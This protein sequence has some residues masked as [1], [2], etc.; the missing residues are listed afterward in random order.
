[1]CWQLG[2]KRLF[3]FNNKDIPASRYGDLGAALSELRESWMKTL[4][5]C[6]VE[7]GGCPYSYDG[8]LI[9]GKER[10]CGQLLS[11]LLNLMKSF[12]ED[13]LIFEYKV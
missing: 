4:L 10:L 5:L 6:R 7:G 13:L 2:E 12:T 9:N 1:M 8:T 11:M 3:F